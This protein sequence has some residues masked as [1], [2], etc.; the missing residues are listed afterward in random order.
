MITG[1]IVY[2]EPR[3][4]KLDH[5][6]G[7]AKENSHVGKGHRAGASVYFGYMSRFFVL[8]FFFCTQDTYVYSLESF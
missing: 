7:G 5:A 1:E 8:L 2:T 3:I 6:R 4:W